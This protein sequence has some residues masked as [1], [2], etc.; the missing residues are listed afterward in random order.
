MTVSGMMITAAGFVML[1]LVHDH[2]IVLLSELALIGVGLG[3]FTPANNAAIMGSAPRAHV[4][5]ASGILNMTR[6]LGTSLGVALTGL[7]YSFAALSQ[8]GRGLMLAAMFLALVSLLAAALAGLRG[9]V[10]LHGQPL[11][12][13]E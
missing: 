4:G 11:V 9:G 2:I 12:V 7:V 10:D 3:A 13:V 6:G 5:V 1:A 8:P